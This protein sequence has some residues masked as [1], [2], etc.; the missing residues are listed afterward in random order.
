MECAICLEEGNLILFNHENKCGDIMVHDSCLTEWFLKNNNECIICR[1]N[2]LNDYELLSS[3]EEV[4]ID[5][6]NNNMED[7]MNNNLF[8]RILR[9]LI[10]ILLLIMFLLLFFLL[11]FM[12]D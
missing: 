4:N 9:I 7:N 10:I 12:M 5:I 6:R 11:V 3:D 8:Y 1:E 2:L